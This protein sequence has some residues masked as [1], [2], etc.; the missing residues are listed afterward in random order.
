MLEILNPPRMIQ[1]APARFPSDQQVE[2][3]VLIGF[4]VGHRADPAPVLHGWR[5]C[6]AWQMAGCC[7]KRAVAGLPT[8][9][10]RQ[11]CSAYGA[12]PEEATL[13]AKALALGVIAEEI[14]HGEMTLAADTLQFSIAA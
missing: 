10:N 9:P 3:D 8:S 6:P 5:R 1:Q 4:A 14:E 7:V 12:T 13:K 11:A 2:V